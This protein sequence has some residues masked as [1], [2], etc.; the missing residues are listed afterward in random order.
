MSAPKQSIPDAEFYPHASAEAKKTVDAH[1]GDAPLKLYSGWFC[2]FVQRVWL[3]LEEKHI[4]Y[5]YIEVNPYHKP[6]SL[7]RLNPRG[8]VPTL[9]H[10]NKPLYESTVVMEFLEDEYPDHKPNLRPDDPHERARLRIWTD[11]VTTRIIPSFHRFLQFQ[12]SSDTKGLDEKRQEFLGHLREWTAE[13]DEEGPYFS[14][15][16]PRLVDFQMGP[17]AV[18]L[19]VFDLMKGG[20]GIPAEGQGGEHE[21]VWNRYRKWVKAIEGRDSVK[22]TTSEREHFLPLYQRYADN[23]AQSELAKATRSGRGVP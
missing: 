18:R 3:V 4:P 5:Q 1:Q 23:T 12:P 21:K 13:M 8:L 22:A 7:L 11:Y 2:P 14:G 19:W 16:E 10:D 17:W 20:L 6:D 15:K 9:E